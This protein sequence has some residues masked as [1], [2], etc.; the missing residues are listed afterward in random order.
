MTSSI[1][2]PNAPL[3]EAVFEIRFPAEP[4]VE[5]HRDDFYE[6]VRKEYSAVHVPKVKGGDAPALEFYKFV[7]PSDESSILVALNRIAFSVKQYHGF[8]AFKIEAMRVM[9]IFAE[10]FKINQLRRIGLR[11]V[12]MINFVREGDAVPIEN[13]LN[14]GVDLPQSFP[15]RFMHFELAFVSKT[16]G[17]S[18]TTRIQPVRSEDQKKEAILLDFDY[19]KED[20]ALV[21]SSLDSY[22]DESH[23]HTKDMFEQLITPTY[24]QF[25]RGETV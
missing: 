3:V 20:D 9:T 24:R 8:A 2:Y 15:G 17:G 18:V 7:R 19:A 13:Y 21:F 10:R 6:L 25:L 12:D 14:V 16:S 11:Y 5:C 23:G 1:L 4:A 22:L